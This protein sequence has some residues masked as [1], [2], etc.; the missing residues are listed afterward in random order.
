MQPWSVAVVREGSRQELAQR[1]LAEFD[2][3]KQASPDYDYYPTENF[4]PFTQRRHE[5]G[6]ALYKAKGIKFSKTQ[7]DW[8]AVL[9]FIRQNY[10]FFGADT[11][12]IFYVDK[13]LTAGA[14]LDIGMFMQNVMLLAEAHGLNTCP[15]AAIGNYPD[16]VRSYLG[17][18]DDVIILCGLAIG[19][20][21]TNHATNCVAVNKASAKHFATWYE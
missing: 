5:I 12:L 8:S 16:V 11:A 10:D 21:D 15:Q 9:Q 3:Q 13:R 18:S 14:N 19:Y 2:S 17:L 7:V 1:L 6:V 20:A 4:A